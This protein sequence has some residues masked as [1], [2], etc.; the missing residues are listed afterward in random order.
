M[1]TNRRLP[2]RVL[3]CVALVAGACAVGSGTVASAGTPDDDP[4]RGLRYNGMEPAAAG[5]CAGLLELPGNASPG[6]PPLCTH[7]PDAAPDGVDVRVPRAPETPAE[8]T[9]RPRAA[10][11]AEDPTCLGDGSSGRRVQLVYANI[12]GRPDRSEAFA[13]SFRIWAA[14]TD[15]VFQRSAAETGGS[16]RIGFVHDPVTCVPTVA[17]ATLSATG[18]VDYWTSAERCTSRA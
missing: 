11:A 14:S 8:T 6:A 13:A 16:R 9:L 7:G 10:V 4:A 3:L 1:C 17:K 5:P 18:E 12:A 15:D 2:L